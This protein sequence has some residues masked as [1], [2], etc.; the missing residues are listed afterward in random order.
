MRVLHLT[1][2]KRTLE[3]ADEPIESRLIASDV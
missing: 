3:P 2:K 1:L